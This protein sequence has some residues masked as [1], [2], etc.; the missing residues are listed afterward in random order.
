MGVGHAPRA[1]RHA[2]F[3]GHAQHKA[4]GRLGIAVGAQQRLG[5]QYPRHDV[6]QQ[7]VARVRV[8]PDRP[9]DL[10]RHGDVVKVNAVHL[11]VEHPDKAQRGRQRRFARIGQLPDRQYAV[12]EVI[13]IQLHGLAQLEIRVGFSAFVIVQ[14]GHARA[15]VGIDGIH[16]RVQPPREDIAPRRKRVV[17][18]QHVPLVLF[19]PDPH[20]IR[21]ARRRLQ[22][23]DRNIH[24]QVIGDALI[25]E[26]AVIA[27]RKGMQQRHRPAAFPRLAQTL[28]KHR[29]HIA[30]A[31]VF[32]I[33]AH[34][35]HAQRP[36]PC[37][38]EA[39]LHR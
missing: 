12:A 24:D 17:H 6:G 15:D 18:P 1:A 29:A 35:A 27:E 36:D 11:A 22:L 4:A 38:A 26:L 19:R 30:A 2:V 39:R 10:G 20:E 34:A 9:I 21:A 28:F 5:I 31:P 8:V 3:V 16:I 14:I 37:L 32:R 33:G 13:D 7:P 23:G 25:A